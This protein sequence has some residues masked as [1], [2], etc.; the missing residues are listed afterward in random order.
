MTKIE[1]GGGGTGHLRASSKGGG[2]TADKKEILMLFRVSTSGPGLLVLVP[3]APEK[4]NT[5]LHMKAAGYRCES[6]MSVRI[7]S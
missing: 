1:R 5:L 2:G 3:P 6:T 7:R 4:T